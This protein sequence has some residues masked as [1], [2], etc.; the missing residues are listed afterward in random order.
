MLQT[1]I[2]HVNGDD[3]E[4]VARVGRM[5]FAYRQAFRKDVVIDMVCYRRRGHNEADN[6]SFTQPLMYDLIEARRS[7]RKL[8]TESLIARGDLTLEEAEAALRDYQQ[9]L[10]RAFTETKEAAEASRPQPGA[11]AR[12]AAEIGERDGHRPRQRSAT[13]ITP[14]RRSSG[15]SIPSSACRTG[16]TAAPAPRAA[17]RPPRG[18]GRA[19]T[20]IDWATGELLAFGGAAHRRPPA[21][22]W[23][24]RTPA[25]APSA[26]GTPVLV[27]RHTGVEY[28]PLQARSTTGTRKFFTPMTRCFPSSPRSD[29]NTATRSPG[30]TPWSAWEAQFGDFVNGA[31]TIVDE[32]IS[33]G[34][35]KWGQKFQRGAAAAAWL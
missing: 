1:P 18:D 2:F 14:G 21:C 9:Q 6:P 16:F 8:Y 35:Q 11:R 10:E 25:G 12:S 15:L 13:A 24:A 33:S 26:S 27:D 23:S 7:V 3:P 22:D 19:P 4:A 17:A 28:T 32:F 29:S 30:R 31:Q 5:A 34:E 20:P